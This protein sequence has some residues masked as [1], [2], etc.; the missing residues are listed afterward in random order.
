VNEQPLTRPSLLVRL[1]DAADAPAWE[2]FVRIYA[3]L[4]YGYARRHGL[5]DADAA[6][7]T[8]EVLLVV[9]QAIRRLDYDPRRGSFRGWL[10]TVVRTRLCNF[11]DRRRIRPGPDSDATARLDAVAAPDANPDAWWQEEYER[12][13]FAWAAEQ[14]RSS[15]EPNTWEAFRLTAVEGRPAVETASRLSLTVAAVYMAK[16][17]ILARLRDLVRT[18]EGE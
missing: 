15:V 17:R 9:S 8:Q 14:V 4:L 13:L 2:Q 6:D 10:L 16:S 5:Q 12:Q 7:L 11:L 1:R 18:V 3:P